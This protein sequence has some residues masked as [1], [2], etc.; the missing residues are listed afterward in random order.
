M[1][2]DFISLSAALSDYDG[3]SWTSASHN[4]ILASFNYR[5]GILG[6]FPSAALDAEFAA[7]S[8][9]GV[10]G[11]QGFQDQQLALH[12]VQDN[13]AAFGGDPSRVTIFGQSAGAS[14]MCWHLISPQSQ[15]LYARVIIESPVACDIRPL[16]SYYEVMIG[17]AQELST[18]LNCSQFPDK[19]TCLRALPSE[20]LIAL[21]AVTGSVSNWNASLNGY[22][23]PNPTLAFTAGAFARV[24][25]M[26]GTNHDEY[27]LLSRLLPSSIYSNETSYNEFIAAD[28]FGSVPL[29]SAFNL[30]NF[31]DDVYDAAVRYQT[32]Q[33]Y[34]CTCGR[35]ANYFA[36]VGSV[37]YLYSFNHTPANGSYDYVPP[38]AF[39]TAEL[40]FLFGNT[41]ASYY[42]IADLAPSE[43]DLLSTMRQLWVNFASSGNPT[44][45]TPSP[46]TPNMTQWP[47]YEA[48]TALGL[49]IDS[50]QAPLNWLVEY[51]LCPLF[52]PVDVERFAAMSNLTVSCNGDICTAVNGSVAAALGDPMLSGFLG[53]RYQVHGLD[54]AVYSIISSVSMQLNA[55]FIF[56]GSGRCPTYGGADA[57]A[58]RPTNC[59]THPGS[60]FGSIGLRTAKGSRLLL[61][62]GGS[63]T[64]F[65][66]ITFDGVDLTAVAGQAEVQHQPE[67]VQSSDLTLTLIDRHHLSVLHGVFILTLDSSDHFINIAKVAID[68][69]SALIEDVQ[70]HGLLGQSWHRLTGTR[71]GLDVAEVEGRVDDYVDSNN[72]IFGINNIHSRFQFKTDVV[73]SE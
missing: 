43:S 7:G 26:L 63:M 38:S 57:G 62:A 37:V 20:D 15:G 39:H 33:L 9:P 50:T 22:D 69:W 30:N 41:P 34:S 64:G 71:R 59:W 47:A 35:L 25:V 12:W 14:F 68:S 67:I 42:V 58:T 23:I 27:T 51:P 13:I 72:D 56:L 65:E 8:V 28:S 66:E 29:I 54:G 21:A 48:S 44:P 55:R 70:P 49:I 10:S 36:A 2:G 45:S 5:L 24:P 19:L 3:L 1:Q 52:S 32:Y 6:F 40:A 60:Y 31:N 61:Q 17:M 11:N 16:P 73:G 53:Q 18:Y 4:F 46:L